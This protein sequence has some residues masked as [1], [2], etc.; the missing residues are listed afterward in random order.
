LPQEKIDALTAAFEG[1][2]GESLTPLK[3][4]YGD[5]FTWGELRLFKAGLTATK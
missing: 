5:T 4:K 3:E 1:F 2:E